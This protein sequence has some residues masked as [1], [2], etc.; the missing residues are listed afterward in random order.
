MDIW[1]KAIIHF[2]TVCGSNKLNPQVLF[3]DGYARNFNNRAINILHPHHTKPFFLKVGDS[4]NYRTNDNG[5]NLNLKGLYGQDRMNW[6]IQH[7]TLNYKNARTNAVLVETL[8]A[9]NFSSAPIIIN[10]FKETKIAPSPHLKNTPTPK[11]VLQQP[12]I[13]KEKKSGGNRS[14]S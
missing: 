3:Y 4:G 11:P 2:K 1:M 12:K 8:R 14:N 6:W 5:K 9:F 10:T 13:P 7:G